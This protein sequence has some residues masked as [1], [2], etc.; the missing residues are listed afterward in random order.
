MVEAADPGRLQWRRSGGAVDIREAV[1]TPRRSSRCPLDALA[2]H[3][4]N[5]HET[6]GRVDGEVGAR[7]C[8]PQAVKPSRGP[9]TAMPPMSLPA[10]A[11]CS[12]EAIAFAELPPIGAQWRHSRCANRGGRVPLM[13]GATDPSKRRE[14]LLWPTEN[15]PGRATVRVRFGRGISGMPRKMRLTSG[16]GQAP[17]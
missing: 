2:L 15:E 8:Y 5:H 10:M 11:R 17:W 4:R 13:E 16:L 6:P 3:S 7:G 9:A 14:G 12:D 1:A